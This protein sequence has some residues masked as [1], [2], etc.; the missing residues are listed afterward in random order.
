MKT[1]DWG[2]RRPTVLA[3]CEKLACSRRYHTTK[4]LISYSNTHMTSRHPKVTG[5][6]QYGLL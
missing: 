3:R 6:A 2:I 4:H 5:P 1:L